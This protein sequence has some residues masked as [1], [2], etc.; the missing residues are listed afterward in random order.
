MSYYNWNNK[1][2]VAIYG[3]NSYSQ[4]LAARLH[5]MNFSVCAYIDRR[6][7]E[8]RSIDG[9]PVY[10]MQDAFF[11][12]VDDNVC[13]VIMLQNAMQHDE[14][15]NE[16]FQK[17]IH[18]IIF[19]PMGLQYNEQYAS[20]LREIYNSILIGDFESINAV[21]YYDSLIQSFRKKWDN[22]ICEETRNFLIVRV[23][24]DIVYTNPR[25]A[26]KGRENLMQYADMPLIAY[27]PYNEMFTYYW[28]GVQDGD[29]TEYLNDYGVNSCTYT[30]TFTDNKII[31]QREQLYELWNEHFQNGIDFFISSAPLAK[32]NQNGYFNLLEGQHRTLFL[33]KKG[34]YYLPIRITRADWDKWRNERVFCRM[35]DTR[36][37]LILTI[38]IQNPYFQNNVFYNKISLIESMLLIQQNLS[39]ELY[40]EKTVLSCDTL[41][42]YY[43]FNLRRMGASEVTVYVDDSKKAAVEYLSDLYGLKTVNFCS[44]IDWKEIYRFALILIVGTTE[45][46]KQIKYNVLKHFKDT[47]INAVLMSLTEMELNTVSEDVK[48]GLIK[49]SKVFLETEMVGIYLLRKEF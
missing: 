27:R 20:L 42:G 11:E 3:I 35:E 43:G 48:S 2:K 6:A 18:K 7:K 36:K 47:E 8:V 13:T 25:E 34:V 22:I 1:L 23:M 10:D 49:I 38:P 5:E 4:M 15:A 17:G 37:K 44:S 24:A 33:L 32:W 45:I 29:I 31:L 46:L 9:V 28:G 30:H 26:V 14:I 12:T 16:L 40:F 41:L 21:P 19:V 39:K